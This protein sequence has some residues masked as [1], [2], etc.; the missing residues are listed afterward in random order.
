MADVKV[1]MD[2]SRDFSTVHGERVPGDRYREVHFFQDR[3]PFDSRGFLISDH[4]DV[5]EDPELA[6][7]VAQKLKKAA[8]SKA[9]APGD[10]PDAPSD[11]DEGDEQ[12]NLSA[13]AR[14]EGQWPWQEISN[15]IGKRF[16]RRVANKQAAIEFLVDEKVIAVADLAPEYQKLVKDLV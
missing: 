1:R 14:G 6:K 10:E 16:N 8:K 4:P 7:L 9:E 5:T 11:K 13:W 2:K 3:L 15:A 12:V